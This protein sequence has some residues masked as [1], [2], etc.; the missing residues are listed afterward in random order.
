MF[1]DY[2]VPAPCLGQHYHTQS[3]VAQDTIQPYP[4]HHEC[5]YFFLVLDN[6][7]YQKK[8]KKKKTGQKVLQVLK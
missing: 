4:E 3:Q 7:A 5:V 2:L 6:P 1:K 8:K